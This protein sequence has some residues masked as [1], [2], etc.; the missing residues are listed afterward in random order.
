VKDDSF[1]GAVLGER[2]HI[3]AE[4]N[5]SNGPRIIT[6]RRPARYSRDRKA[7]FQRSQFGRLVELSRGAADALFIWTAA[8]GIKRAICR[9][10]S[11]KALSGIR[12]GAS[13]GE[14]IR[15]ALDHESISAG[16]KHEVLL[17][18]P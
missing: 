15:L 1:S 6:A 17:L 3:R 11:F 12:N 13:N 5:D 4:H 10:D 2:Y 16:R 18:W 9:V 14:I 8:F 7:S